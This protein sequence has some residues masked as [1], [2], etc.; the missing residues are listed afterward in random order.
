MSILKLQTMTPVATESA[1]A[2]I[3]STSSSSDCCKK[4]QLKPTA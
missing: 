2:V 3:S 4:Q 1:V